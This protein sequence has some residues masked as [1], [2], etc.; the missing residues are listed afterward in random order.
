M[1]VS[2]IGITGFIGSNVSRYLKDLGFKVIGIYRKDFNN[3][4][5]LKKKI[6]DSDIIINVSGESIVGI[7][8]KEKKRNIYKSRVFIT[9]KIVEIIN[10]S[11]KSYLFINASAVGIYDNINIHTEESKSYDKSFLVDVITDW[12]RELYN[13][14]NNRTRW[15]ILRMGIIID[16]RGGYLGKIDYM[17]KKKICFI[18][19][20]KDEYFPLISLNELLKIIHFIIN[21]KKVKGIVNAVSDLQIKI[22][23]F[24]KALMETEKIKLYFKIP[25]ICLKVILGEAS[26]I[27]LRGQKVIPEKLLKCGFLFND[28]DIYDLLKSLPRD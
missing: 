27:F 9:R 13:I 16:K 7:W 1:N 17:L 26:V 18:I 28:K 2:V 14:N 22:E 8:T 20:K 24:Y 6:E 23:D 21:T 5:I 3:S 19:G 4:L 12:E 25:D 15:I 11:K 10:R